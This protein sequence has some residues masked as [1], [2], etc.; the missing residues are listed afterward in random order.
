MSAPEQP[1]RQLAEEAATWFLR[2]REGRASA[3]RQQEFSNWLNAADSHR[4][5]YDRFQR[6]WGALDGARPRAGQQRRVAAALAVLVLALGLVWQNPA[7]DLEKT[8]KIGERQHISLADGSEIDLDGRT[9]IQVEQ[10]FFSRRLI[11]EHGQIFVRVAPGLRPFVVEAGGGEIRDIGTAFNVASENG[12]VSVSVREGIVDISPAAS[13]ERFRVEAGQRLS[14]AG[15]AVGSLRSAAADA[16]ES[17]TSGRWQFDDVSLAEVVAQ[18]NRQHE[19]PVYLADARLERYRVSGVFAAEDRAALLQALTR[20][21][22]L[23]LDETASG[24]RIGPR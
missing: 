4:A 17:W 14:Y 23:R 15:Q 1:E 11:L 5:E 2:M 19:R 22:P 10:G 3:R 12:Q 24:T 16:S 20:L 13:R 8:T 7:V 6:L 21:Y 18:I 9:R